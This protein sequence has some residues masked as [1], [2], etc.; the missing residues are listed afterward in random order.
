MKTAICTI[1]THS[2]LFKSYSLL[3]SVLDYCQTDVF[4]LLT[5]LNTSQNQHHIY[6]NS[7][8]DLSSDESE[9]IKKKYKS[10]KLRWALK[11]VYLK[12]LLEKG[13]EQ[14]IYCD[15][16]IFF[17]SSPEF[18]FEK[19]RNSAF[20]LTPHFYKSNPQEDQHWLEANYRV[21][22]Y[23]AGFIGVSQKGIPILDWWTSCCMYN[24]KKSFWRGLFDDQKYL[25]L[26]PV[27][28]DEVEVVKNKGCNLA[29]WNVGNYVLKRNE[30][31][32]LLVQDKRLVFVHFTPLSLTEFSKKDSLLLE[33]FKCYEE[34]LK[35]HK[36]EYR[37]IQTKK[38]FR[39]WV[40]FG[41]FLRWKLVRLFE[42][43]NP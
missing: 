27:L 18:L 1:S 14:V 39:E 7:L 22:L 12:F 36:P 31:N 35:K 15:N 24:V 37:F 13:Y 9:V 4:C 23:N 34:V 38:S 29:G 3:E 20:L 2:H 32:L 30:Q 43:K 16:D 17:Y 5:D 33:E 21:G 26:V 19:L 28:F 11:P 40:A 41:Y 25:D 6:F 8:S 42:N 10:D